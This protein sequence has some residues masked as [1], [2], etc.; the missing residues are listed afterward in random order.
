MAEMKFSLKKEKL[1]QLKNKSNK[2]KNKKNKLKEKFVPH[3][4]RFGET[5]TPPSTSKQWI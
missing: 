5:T 2:L 1:K 3:V 4:R